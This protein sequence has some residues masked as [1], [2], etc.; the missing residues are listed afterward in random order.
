MFHMAHITRST[1][2][3]LPKSEAIVSNK[4]KGLRCLTTLSIRNPVLNPK[5]KKKKF[6]YLIT[7]KINQ[8]FNINFENI[9]FLDLLNY[10][11]NL[12]NQ[13]QLSQI[14]PINH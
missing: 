14:F 12:P 9:F 11:Y 1:T 10:F 8:K 13:K 4:N 3:I 2:A 6:Y 7:N 5:K